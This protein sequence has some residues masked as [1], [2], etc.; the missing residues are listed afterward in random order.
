[1]YAV[2]VVGAT[3]SVGR[4]MLAILAERQFPVETIYAL[5]SSRSVGSEVQFGDRDVKVKNLE[6][7]DFAGV[8]LVL[9][10]PGASVSRVFAPKAA[11]AGAVVIDNTSYFRMHPKVPLIVPEVNADAA[12]PLFKKS[13]QAKIIANPNCSTIQMLTALAPIHRKVG[14][15]RIVVATYQSVSGGGQAAMDELFRQTKAVY[16]ND[17]V[18]SEQF[19]KPIAFN[20]IPHI[21][22]FMEDGSTREEWKM[23]VET[24]KILDPDIKVQASCVRIPV[25]VGHG[26][27]V[28]L[29]LQAPLTVQGART[30]LQASPGVSV[31][32]RR[33]DGGYV[34]P[35]EC[36]GED[37]VYVSRIR[38]DPTVEHGL[39]MWIASD[40]LRKG[41]ALNSVQIAESLIAQNLI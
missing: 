40:N 12:R 39:A 28:N 30:L 38:R 15:R 33:E 18:K 6:H 17:V 7:F 20:C 11:K 29:E 27:A 35:K 37:Q 36:A 26:E 8:D 9:S 10:S 22:S 34:T 41:A 13:N 19:T 1:M 32:D 25:F 3:G 4:E 5:A 14:I 16:T 2:A 23:V 31:F 21:D 24:A